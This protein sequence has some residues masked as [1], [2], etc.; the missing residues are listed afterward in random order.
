MIKNL[1]VS[2]PFKQLQEDIYSLEI[3][4]KK[5]NGLLEVIETNKE[6]N[7]ILIERRVYYA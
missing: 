7:T 4:D 5:I 6:L 2:D 3:F 1:S